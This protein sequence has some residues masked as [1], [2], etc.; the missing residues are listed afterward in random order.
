MTAL[1]K[2]KDYTTY[3]S[4]LCHA[5]KYMGDYNF[6]NNILAMVDIEKLLHSGRKK[7]ALYTIAMIDYISKENN[8]PIKRELE[9]YRKMKMETLSFSSGVEM[10]TKIVKND[11]MKNRAL[12]F[13][14]KEFLTYNIVET[15]VRNVS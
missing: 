5:L 8:I 10:Y 9:N 3:T 14:I 1:M 15:S 12:S 13:A 7:H 2:Y 4:E 6:V 11:D